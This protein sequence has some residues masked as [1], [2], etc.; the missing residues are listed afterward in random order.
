M[1]PYKTPY[2]HH[3]NEIVRRDRSQVITTVLEK[4]SITDQALLGVLINVVLI[5]V[6]LLSR[7]SMGG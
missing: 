5:V 1:E 4:N 7:K 2:N 3:Q 6:L